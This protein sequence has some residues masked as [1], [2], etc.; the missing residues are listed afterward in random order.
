MRILTF[1][2]ILVALHSGKSQNQTYFDQYKPLVSAGTLP[3]AIT[4]KSGEAYEKA[5][6]KIE[7]SKEQSKKKKKLKEFALNNQFAIDNVMRSGHILF[8]D[9]VSAYLKQVL[10]Q[11]PAQIDSKKEV[12][13]YVLRTPVVNAFA[14]DR[15]TIFV[16]LGLLAHVENEAQLAFILAHELAHIKHNHSLNLFLKSEGLDK[17]ASKSTGSSSKRSKSVIERNNF[18][19]EHEMEADAKGFAT[20]DQSGY[21]FETISNVFEMLKYADQPFANIPVRRDLFEG[22]NFKLPNLAW[23]DTVAVVKGIAEDEDDEES[24]HPNLKKRRNAFDKLL[25]NV[26][27]KSGKTYLVS[28]SYFN[29]VRTIARFEISRAYLHDGYTSAAIYNSYALLNE[30]PNNPYLKKCIGQALYINAKYESESN[31]TRNKTWQFVEGNAQS[32]FY[33][34]DT[35]TSREATVLATRY[36]WQLHQEQPN[37][38]DIKRMASDVLIELGAHVSSLSEIKEVVIDDQTKPAHPI[39]KG[40]EE[41][42]KTTK[43]VKSKKEKPLTYRERKKKLEAEEKRLEK[44]K[45]EREGLD[46]WRNALVQFKEDSAFVKAFNTG[47]KEYTYRKERRENFDIAKYKERL[48]KQDKHGMMLG[49][50]KVLILNPVYRYVNESKNESHSVLA[51]ERKRAHMLD[52]MEQMRKKVGLDAQ[53]IDVQAFSEKDVDK[54]NEMRHLVDWYDEQADYEQLPIT[55]GV[56][57]ERVNEIAKKYGT[58]QL[59]LTGVLSSKESNAADVGV[60]IGMTIFTG[61][62]GLFYLPEAIKPNYESLFFAIL[63]DLNDGTYHVVKFDFMHERDSDTL[64]KQQYYDVFNQLKTKSAKKK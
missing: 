58:D 46:H 32:V 62:F 53:V 48:A 55:F 43:K 40:S 14:V 8:G 60:A 26:S 64:L 3:T 21:S 36:L 2:L 9:T 63:V 31:F 1:L 33:L 12:E 5:A 6:K 59:L 56:D 28:E 34:M 47:Q 19:K 42:V 49:V 22:G 51:T 61:P 25:S 54:F 13:I 20:F 10:K 57:Q 24:T 15:G 35:L 41:K 44:L 52:V 11:L 18:S 39:A 29:L 16:S 7:S 27:D 37:D 45:E 23:L 17:S 50:K 38:A 4:N 30:F